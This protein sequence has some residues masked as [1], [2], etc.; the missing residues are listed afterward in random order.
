MGSYKPL[1][2]LKQFLSSCNYLYKYDFCRIHVLCSFIVFMIFI[3][4]GPTVLAVGPSWDCLD[5]WMDG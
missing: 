3:G 1:F 2:I 5:G 4:Q